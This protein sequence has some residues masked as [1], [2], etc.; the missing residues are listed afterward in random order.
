MPFLNKVFFS[1]KLWKSNID[2]L[3]MPFNPRTDA[4]VRKEAAISLLSTIA[5]SAN[6]IGIANK[7]WPGSVDPNPLS[8]NFGKIKIGNTRFDVT[9]GMGSMITLITRQIQNKSKSAVTGITNK[10]GEG[11]DPATRYSVLLDFTENKLSPMFSV[12]KSI[13][14]GRTFGGEKTTLGTVAQGLTVPIIG[15]NYLELAD[16]P[17]S[18]NV[19]LAMIADSLGMS[20]NTYTYKTNWETSTSKELKQFKAVKGDEK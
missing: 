18:A 6:L 15:E 16:D 13:A 20:T 12:I 17:N 1:V 8:A 11:F 10:F 7:L 2:L 4:F 3:T 19:V 5:G 14:E 9:G